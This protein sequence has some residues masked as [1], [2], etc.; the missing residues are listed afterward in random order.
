MFK[1]LKQK[2]EA[3]DEGGIERLSFSTS[4][5]PG[6]VVRSPPASEAS[7]SFSPPV[8][9]PTKPTSPVHVP[10]LTAVEGEASRKSHSPAEEVI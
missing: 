6:S 7:L 9:H 2:I 4:R 1:K 8:L 5:T 3:G 10:T